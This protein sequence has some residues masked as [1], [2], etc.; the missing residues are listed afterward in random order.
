MK[1]PEYD[2][3]DNLFPL[4]EDTLS[5]GFKCNLC[6]KAGYGFI[7]KEIVWGNGD[8]NAN[9][10]IVG[11]D[12]A[13]AKP[14]ERLWRASKLTLLPLSNKKTGAKFR[15]FLH[16][17]G[18]NPFDVFITNVVKCNID[19]NPT[20]EFEERSLPCRQ[21]LQWE[22][23]NVQPQIIISL[24]NESTEVV[25]ELLDGWTSINASNFLDGPL[26]QS[27]PPCKA[28]Y[29]EASL[30]LI[31][32]HHPSRVEGIKRESDYVQNLRFVND[33]LKS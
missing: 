2:K 20:E 32:M 8:S 7:G 31:P 1:K 16:K 24:G 26:L 5:R 3:Y 17:A 29:G 10:L 25:K 21:H 12:S 28:R 22:F 18:F 4:K 23:D 11:K 6:D 14:K 33:L 30:I 13:G 27:H 15:I 19:Y 9:L